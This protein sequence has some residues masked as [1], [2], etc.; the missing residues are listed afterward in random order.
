MK[1]TSLWFNFVAGVSYLV[2]GSL[3]F[4]ALAAPNYVAHEWGTFTSVQGADGGQMA[5]NPLSVTDLPSFGS[6]G[7]S[8][9]RI[10]SARRSISV[11][12]ATSSARIISR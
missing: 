1:K 4:T 7:R 2:G 10:S 12:A 11:S 9:S 8:S 5:W 6:R 3:Y